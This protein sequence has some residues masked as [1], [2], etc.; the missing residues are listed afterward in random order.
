MPQIT[1]QHAR[2][3]RL[4]NLALIVKLS[5]DE[6]LSCANVPAEERHRAEMAR[7]TA[8]MLMRNLDALNEVVPVFVPEAEV[9]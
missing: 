9:A 4:T 7:N 2:T 8:V 6:W 1:D 3:V 5:L